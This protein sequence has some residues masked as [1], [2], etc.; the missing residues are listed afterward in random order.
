MGILHDPELE[1]LLAALHARSDAQIPVI[2]G[3]TAQQATPDEMKDFRRD[4]LVALDRD[5]A[6]FC[7]QLC[8]ASDARRIVEIGTSYGVS[9]LYL[10]AAV[11]DN[12]R[13]NGGAGTVIGTEYEPE[14][15][16][17]ARA[18]FAQA[19]L[20]QLIDLREGDL[21]ETLKQIDGPVD[22]VLVDI[23]I[24]MARPALERVAQHLRP[25]A[26]VVC[27]NTEQHREAYADYFAFLNDP[28]N[29]FRTMTLPF[30]GG[31]EL[32]VR[33]PA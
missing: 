32:S 6:E 17:A 2:A 22:F 16:A 21:R 18:H 25:G 4:K 15:A 29:R 12:I 26:I 30:G 5:K 9:T 10:A 8:R 13:T 11:R 27:D 24:A 31:F 23:W 1:Q 20:S 28:A 33:C 7:Y 14:K 3:Y 19:G